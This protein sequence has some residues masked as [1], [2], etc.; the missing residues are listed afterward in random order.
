MHPFGATSL[1]IPEPS[2]GIRYWCGIGAG[3]KC[4]D[5]TPAGPVAPSGGQ[6]AWDLPRFAAAHSADVELPRPSCD[7]DGGKRLETLDELIDLV[8]LE[9]GV[10]RGGELVS[11]NITL[12][13]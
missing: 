9:N 3:C 8:R 12:I 7:E 1:L 11:G 4:G 10:D 6:P 13:W 5:G 2:A